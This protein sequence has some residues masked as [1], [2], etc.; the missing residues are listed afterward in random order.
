MRHRLKDRRGIAVVER[1]CNADCWSCR[2]LQLGEDLL[3]KAGRTLRLCGGPSGGGLVV[4]SLRLVHAGR[5]KRH[6]NKKEVAE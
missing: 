2:G 6:K 4:A 3:C 1:V 5:G